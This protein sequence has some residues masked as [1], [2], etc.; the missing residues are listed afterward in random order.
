MKKIITLSFLVLHLLFYAQEPDLLSLIQEPTASA[1]KVF[2]T[3]KTSKIVNAQSIET[4]KHKCLDFRIMHRFDDIAVNGSA[5]TLWGFDNSNDIRFSFDYGLTENLTLGF[6]RSKYNELLEL[7]SKWRFLEQTTTN[8]VPISIAA[9]FCTG[10]SPV[11]EAFFYSGVDKN[12]P[13]KFTHS[14]NWWQ[15]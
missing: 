7:Y 15:T 10:F 11:D 14:W 12:T 4:V 13:H 9:Y 6:S 3:F 1:E 8:S 5:H 2:A